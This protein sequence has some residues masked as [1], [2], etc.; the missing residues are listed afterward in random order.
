ML[1]YRTQ[2]K[3]D[4]QKL[5][6]LAVPCRNGMHFRTGLSTVPGAGAGDADAS[7]DSGRHDAAPRLL[8]GHELL[9]K[10][11]VDQQVGQ[12][13]VAVIGLPSHHHT[14]R[15]PMQL[16]TPEPSTSTCPILYV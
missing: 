14:D 12:G 4:A 13:G 10:L 2:Y 6:Q 16:H 15:Q 3:S 7:L 9:S 1:L 8:P 5:Y 11:W